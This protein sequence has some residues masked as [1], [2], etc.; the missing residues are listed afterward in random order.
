MYARSLCQRRTRMS[1][2]L[3]LGLDTV[4]NLCQGNSTLWINLLFIYWK[5]HLGAMEA[6]KLNLENR[7]E[8]DGWSEKRLSGEIMETKMKMV[9]NWR[10][11]ARDRAVSSLVSSPILFPPVVVLLIRPASRLT[12]THQ[13][14]FDCMTFSW[15]SRHCSS[16]GWKFSLLPWF[17][18]P[19]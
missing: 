19:H 4:E 6:V 1:L 17:K 14:T 3:L 15:L 12:T 16:G 10:I 13:T 11:G 8:R 18:H 2:Y 9:M 5:L 7:L